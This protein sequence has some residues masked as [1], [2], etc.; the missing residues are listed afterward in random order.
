MDAAVT[1][2]LRQALLRPGQ[3]QDELVY[4]GD[5]EPESRH[6]AAT[7]AGAVVGIASVSRQAPPGAGSEGSKWFR[8]RGMATLPEHR[9]RGI[10]TALLER[11]AGYVA[12]R[13]GD[14]MWCNARVTAEGFYRRSGFRTVGEPFELAGIGPHVV[15][16]RAVDPSGEG[17]EG[18][19]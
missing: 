17:G 7:V 14:T 10:G 4:P 12:E 13:G 8:L 18:G 1:R 11:V 16:V 2:P 3:R 6:F 15:M 19:R 5:L 9:G